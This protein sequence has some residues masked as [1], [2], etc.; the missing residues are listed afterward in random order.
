MVAR[1]ISQSEGMIN[2]REGRDDEL[3]AAL[4]LSG[5]KNHEIREGRYCFQT[6]Y[7]NEC[8]REYFEH[9]GSYHLIWVLRNPY[10]VIH[11]MLYNWSRF[12]LNELFDACG[13][14]YLDEIGR[15]RY[16]KFGRIAVGR[17]K[18]ACLSYKGKTLQLFDLHEQLGDRLMVVDYD[19]LVSGGSLVLKKIYTFI[20]LPY[21]SSYEKY[22]NPSSIKKAE[23]LPDRIRH[24]IDDEAIPVYKSAR[25]FLNF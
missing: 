7:L 12:A 9:I 14:Q 8:Y 6:T 17:A 3:D 25:R 24:M 18:R 22:I 13:A 10:S 19:E 2:Y 5:N 1:I 21:K 15:T 23:S 20:D 11:S 4:I 16:E